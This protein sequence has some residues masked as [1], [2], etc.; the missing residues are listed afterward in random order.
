M[1]LLGKTFLLVA[2]TTATFAFTASAAEFAA[3]TAT[4]RAFFTGPRFIHGQG[5][6]LEVL[7][8]K[9]GDGFGRVFL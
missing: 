1:S 4:S 5:A 6:T 9:H 2:I 3:S 7:L 8:V